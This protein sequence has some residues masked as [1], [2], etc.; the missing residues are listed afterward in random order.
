MMDIAGYILAGGLNRRMNGEK[1]LFLEY[2]GKAFYRHILHA[3]REFPVTYLSVEEA[4]PYEGLGLPLVPDAYAQI[5]PVGGIYSGLLSCPEEALFVAACD[6][7]L[8]DEASVRLLVRAYEKDHR[9]TVAQAG[10][11][12]HPLFG[13]YPK[14]ALRVFEQAIERQD[15]RMM[16][17]LDQAGYLAVQLPE[18]CS[19]VENINTPEAYRQLTKEGRKDE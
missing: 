18:G 2:G 1:K 8:V 12:I 5:G 15:Y 17:V 11:R 13:V 9:I 10:E 7:P 16:H 3:F 4:G 19:A 14:T 6:M